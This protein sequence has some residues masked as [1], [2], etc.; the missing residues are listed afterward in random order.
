MSTI[1]RKGM[2]CPY[3]GKQVHGWTGL[4]E[5][6]RL[7]K[8]LKRCKKNLRQ[9]QEHSIMDALRIRSNSGQ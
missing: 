8:H 1:E 4:H 7:R 6:L 9:G 2:N 3:C 5:L